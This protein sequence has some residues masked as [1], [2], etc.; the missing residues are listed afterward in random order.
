[1]S[2]QSRLFPCLLIIEI[3]QVDLNLSLR[4]RKYTAGRSLVISKIPPYSITWEV[5]LY[6]KFIFLNRC[7]NIFRLKFQGS[8]SL[9]LIYQ[10]SILYFP[11]LSE[12]FQRLFIRSQIRADFKIYSS[13]MM[14]PF[15]PVLFSLIWCIFIF[16]FIILGNWRRHVK[17]RER[18]RC[19]VVAAWFVFP[20]VPK[21][22]CSPNTKS[23]QLPSLLP[24]K[25]P[26]KPED[27]IKGNQHTGHV[28][29]ERVK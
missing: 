3:F 10:N 1:M 14:F 26:K 24:K 23:G 7:V 19:P 28:P 29:A 9:H 6:L 2:Y 15:L 22:L 5:V 25:R 11:F 27:T 12:A 8:F 17:S 18:F 4:I 16:L 13:I 21:I 20:V